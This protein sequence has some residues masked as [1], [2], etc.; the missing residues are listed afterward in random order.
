MKSDVVDFQ[1]PLVASDFLSELQVAVHQAWRV[2][3]NSRRA[4]DGSAPEAR[5]TVA[6]PTRA[7]INTGTHLPPACPLH[8][9]KH[10]Q[11]PT[12]NHLFVPNM[13]CN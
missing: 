6:V 3:L 12:V 4:T 1:I 5:A 11:N 8:Q 9:P 10:V 7:Q 2:A 13:S